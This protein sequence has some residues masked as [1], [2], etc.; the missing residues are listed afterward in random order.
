[1]RS[2]NS[3]LPLLNQNITT[4]TPVNSSPFKMGFM[5][6]SQAA[7]VVNVATGLTATF[8]LMVSL[9]GSN[10]Y[11]SGQILPNTIGAAKIFPVQY[12][13]GFPFVLIQVIQSA[14]SGNVT[15]TG[16]AKGVS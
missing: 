16:S 2:L 7:W 15:I 1:M 5:A 4:S 3:K 9:D 10:Y 14:G 13:G 11:D 8:K 6:S 12:S